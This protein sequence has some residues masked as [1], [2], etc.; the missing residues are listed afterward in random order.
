[1]HGLTDY[2]TDCAWEDVFTVW[3][4]LVDDT[5]QQLYGGQRLRHSGPPPVF[6]DS[7]VITLSLIADS[8]FHG[9]EELTLSFVGQYHRAL[10]P[11]VLS[12]SRF[13]R[14]R[15]ALIALIEGIRRAL[16]DLLI[17]PTDAWRL[18][19]SAPIPVCTYQ[20]SRHCA[21]LAGPEY[22]SVMPS[23]RAKLFGVRLFLTTSLDQVLDQWLLAPAAPRDGKMAEV[24]L[25]DAACLQ[26]IG[27]NAFRDFGV[28]HHLHTTR[29]I[30]LW[31]PPRP[32]YDKVQWPVHLRHL[33]DRARRRVESAISVLATVFHI[34]Q[35]GS[36]SLSGLV[37]RVAARLLAYTISFLASAV[38]QPVHN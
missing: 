16:S 18:I 21:T 19:D 5:Y 32:R 1:M 7:E 10:F 9:H 17:D 8:Y 3:Y 25:E 15:R 12:R 23:R 26:L 11:K 37:A 28:A 27:D 24:L 2:I 13:N 20:R 29:H 6:S 14:R 35:P 4:V 30:Q 38:L 22:Y 34:E 36:R 31:A 33:A